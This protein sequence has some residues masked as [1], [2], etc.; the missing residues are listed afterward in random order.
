[1]VGT[2]EQRINFKLTTEG[3]QKFDNM[4]KGNALG[5]KTNQKQMS[6]FLDEIGAKSKNI[7]L[8]TDTLENSVEALKQQKVAAD[9]AKNSWKSFFTRFQPGFLSLMFGGMQLQRVMGTLIRG[10]IT[11][12]KELAS[13]TDPTR[14]ALT[15]LEGSLKFLKFQIV[16]AAGPL[17][18]KFVDWLSNLANWIARA[19]PGKLK[20]IAISIGALWTLGFGLFAIGQLGTF[21][22]GLGNLIVMMTGANAANA[23]ANMNSLATGAGSLASAMKKGIGGGA[24]VLGLTYTVEGAKA[25]GEGKI[26]DGFLTMIGG[27]VTTV[28]GIRLLKGAKGGPALIAIGLTLEA[29]GDENG[30]QNVI[31]KF[32]NTFAFIGAVGA[33]TLDKAFDTTGNVDF[34]D[35]FKEYYANSLKNTEGMQEWARSVDE[36]KFEA[37]AA[38]VPIDELGTGFLETGQLVKKF[39]DETGEMIT[40]TDGFINVAPNQVS[41]LKEIKEALDEA[42]ESARNYSSAMKRASGQDDDGLNYTPASE[43]NTMFVRN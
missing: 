6:K 1:M 23:A 24:V 30:F 17:L 40:I 32:R 20:A 35:K 3:F 5:L 16:S 27:L 31:D 29:L 43:V 11:N 14:I 33:A 42:A 9:A 2:I 38:K 41:V 21:V 10:M 34:S 19:D 7:K 18:Q 22:T 13:E 4:L 37:T 28:G 8:A 12:F 25:L 39:R 15:R 26:A 36:A